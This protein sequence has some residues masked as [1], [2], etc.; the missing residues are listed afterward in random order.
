[1][2]IVPNIRRNVRHNMPFFDYNELGGKITISS[3]IL[4]IFKK[5]RKIMSEN[6]MLETIFKKKSQIEFK[7]NI[8]P[9]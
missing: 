2:K 3:V 6:L 8:F 4:G 5:I 9:N 1:M 7:V